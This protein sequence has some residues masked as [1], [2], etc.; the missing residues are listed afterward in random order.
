MNIVLFG[1]TGMVGQGVLR[2]CLLASDVQRV[3]SVVRRPSGQH[4]AKLREVAV[5]DF[6]D[7][8]AVEHDLTNLDACFYCVGVTSVGMSEAQYRAVTYD[9]TIAAAT[10]LLRLKPNLTFVFVSG[11]GADST[12]QGRVMWA[13]V[14]G[15]TENALARLTPKSYAFR[16]SLIRPMHGIRSRTPA[17][18][19]FYAAIAPIAPHPQASGAQL[20]DD[21]GSVGPRDA[22]GGAP[23]VSEA[24]PR[25]AR[26]QLRLAGC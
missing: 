6:R 16:P 21:D 18:R 24:H 26:H 15:A 17:Y 7:F 14:K 2:E 3:V 25:N 1:G 11:A 23:R 22:R 4:H 13:R 20:R 8:S 9:L 5:A 19:V 10:T 12:E